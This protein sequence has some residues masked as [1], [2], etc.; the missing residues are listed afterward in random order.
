MRIVGN[1]DKITISLQDKSPEEMEMICEILNRDNFEIKSAGG[2]QDG[3][4]F[5]EAFKKN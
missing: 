5:I 2:C 4:L 1:R 3:K